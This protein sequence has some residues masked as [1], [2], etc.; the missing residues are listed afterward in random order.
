MKKRYG[1][2]L[3][4]PVL[5]HFL[6]SVYVLGS[7][8]PKAVIYKLGNKVKEFKLVEIKNKNEK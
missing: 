6:Q 1:V 2:K 7:V 8:W 3:K 5:A 4:K